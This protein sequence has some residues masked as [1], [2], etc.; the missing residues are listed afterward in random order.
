MKITSLAI[1]GC[2]SIL[3]AFICHF[4]L[5]RIYAKY[6][7]VSMTLYLRL[8]VKLSARISRLVVF[9]LFLLAAATALRL[10][11]DPRYATTFPEYL[12]KF[13][14]ALTDGGIT[15]AF[16]T[17]LL[18]D[19]RPRILSNLMTYVNIHLRQIAIAFSVF[20]PAMSINWIIFPLD[21]W[22]LYKAISISWGSHR[23]ATSVAL[24]YAASPAALD[25]LCNYYVPAKPLANFSIIFTL[26]CMA[27]A[28]NEA[29]VNWTQKSNFYIY[30]ASIALL[31][32]L[33]C[34]ET[35]IFT[36]LLVPAVLRERMT[37][38]Q[39]HAYFHISLATVFPALAYIAIGFGLLPALNNMLGQ[40]PLN[41]WRVATEGIFAA[42][43]DI[44]VN[45]SW[46]GVGYSPV[47]LIE[48][49]LSAH[50]VPLRTLPGN[51]TSLNHWGILDWQPYEQ[52]FLALVFFSFIFLYQRQ[53]RVTRLRFFML[54]GSFLL[55]CLAQAALIKPLAPVLL[56]VNYYAGASSLWFSLMAGLL[57]SSGSCT[58]A[59][60]FRQTLLFYLI[61][62]QLSNFLA[63]V[64]RHPHA[65]MPPPTWSDMFQIQE[66]V[67]EGQFE[68]FVKTHKFPDRGFM[69]A[70]EMEVARRKE[71]GY[72]VD[73]VPHGSNA[74]AIISTLP[75][76]GTQD[77]IVFDADVVSNL[78]ESKLINSNLGVLVPLKEMEYKLFKTT[79]RGVAGPWRYIRVID[80]NG[81]FKEHVWFE[82][83]VRQ[84]QVNGYLKKN[85][86]QLCTYFTN[87][88]L[89]EC[90]SR[91]YRTSDGHYIG[92]S[93]SN[94]YVTSFQILE[95]TNNSISK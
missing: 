13:L 70:Y 82:G 49:I 30:L 39:R 29:K 21:I 14:P 77:L 22:F 79:I 59:F 73:L 85:N 33:L 43:F 7:V 31:C 92:Y 32:G 24:I 75:R 35:A 8:T 63:T 53:E 23:V 80:E 91:I 28:L 40:T 88:T 19:P 18:G 72:L 20:I 67:H 17:V 86:E 25:I 94:N 5:W 41:F 68:E 34:D 69:W 11:F 55:F 38:L 62:V 16:D 3:I 87:T 58:G 4:I 93:N 64:Q 27:K 89:F 50:T 44:K 45:S 6:K 84:W 26:F 9:L 12:F 54:F 56:E 48:T 46:S 36:Y 61:A 81:Q 37:G 60:I 83:I 76:P 51:W 52:V 65:S 57:I 90:V 42:L 78:S 1:A 74:G 71:S 10:A 2:A 47:N 66:K 95:S 15:A